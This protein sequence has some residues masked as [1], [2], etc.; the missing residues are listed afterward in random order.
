LGGNGEPPSPADTT[1]FASHR[2]KWQPQTSFQQTME[3][4]RP[5]LNRYR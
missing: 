3:M 1:T 5:T 2:K 4:K